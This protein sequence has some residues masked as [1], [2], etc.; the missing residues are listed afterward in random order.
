MSLGHACARLVQAGAVVA[1]VSLVAGCGE[2][3]RP[4]VTPVNTS[5]PPAQPTSYAVAISA[6]SPT[7][8]GIV[9]IIDYS[10]DSILVEAPI[11][12]GP[13]TFTIDE[14][15]S[16]GYTLDSDGTLSNFQ[17]STSL[18]AKN[19]SFSTLSTS[20]QPG[21]PHPPQNMFSPASGLWGADLDGSFADDFASIPEDFKLAI[22][23]APVT[24]PV[25]IVGPGSN[26]QRY[27]AINQNI[28]GTP[29]GVECN[30]SPT[31]GPTGSAVAIETASLTVSASIPVGKCPVY[32][33]QSPD[34]K[35][36]FV[37]NR[38]DDTITVINSQNNTVDACTPFLNQNGQ[39]V[40]CH[41]SQ[42]GRAH[43]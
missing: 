23:M 13:R 12:P 8:P 36:F 11:G 14:T 28:A 40:N 16:F 2:G 27:Y 19:V 26:G 25:T 4:V 6:P 17:I 7:A 15:A 35:R 21:P 10:G 24:T 37:L 38:G 42:I 29:S 41:P 5:G 43:V 1:V 32:A 30:I 9:T 3:Y 34:A 18:Q 33:V 20:A 39:T 22:P 31:T